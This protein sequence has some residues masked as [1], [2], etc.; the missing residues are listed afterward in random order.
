[1]DMISAGPGGRP[2]QTPP[3]RVLRHDGGIA[4]IVLDRPEALNAINSE[5]A[6]AL[7]RACLGL[8]AAPE[9]RAVVLSAA[10]DR[11]FCVGADL[12]ERH[13][14]TGAQVTPGEG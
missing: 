3:L 4:D 2:P 13:R 6:H 11:A 9:V 1:M 12:K 10:G 8:A 7:I 14:M 5:L